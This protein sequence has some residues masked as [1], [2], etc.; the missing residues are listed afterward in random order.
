MNSRPKKRAQQEGKVERLA[1]GA[2]PA[3]GAVHLQP[4]AGQEHSPAKAE[5][6]AIKVIEV[7][8]IRG[9]EVKRGTLRTSQELPDLI[10]RAPN[11][12][13]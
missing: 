5:A 9:T 2:A 11:D 10:T 1:E 7:P 3:A 4:G 12:S 6:R 13:K 8:A